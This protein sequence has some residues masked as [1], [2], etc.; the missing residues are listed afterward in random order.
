MMMNLF[1]IF[2]P[3]S[4][5]NS[6]LNWLSMMIM[7]TLTPYYFWIIPSRSQFIFNFFSTYLYLEMKNLFKKKK[8]KFIILFINLF[9]MILL[10]NFMGLFPYIFT[11]TSHINLSSSMALPLWLSFM[12]YGW[13]NNTNYMF[14]HLVP[15]GTPM[16]LSMFM[17]L[18]ETI[19]NLIRPLTL[20]V[21]LSAN[22]ISG[23]L[24]LCLLSNIMQNIPTINF[25][26]IPV[27]MLLLILEMA[28]ATIQSY[29]FITLTALYLNELN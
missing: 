15:L 23:H 1:S 22:M 17:V 27:M 25:L 20:S 4:S 10:M 26:I 24:L 5:F 12:M 13:I 21:R 28:V 7:F 3:S 8:T 18:I 14:I 19:S 16:I 29:V 2:D 6:N 11:P 9:W